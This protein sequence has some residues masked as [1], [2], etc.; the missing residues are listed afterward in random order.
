[1]AASSTNGE[2]QD[3]VRAE[4]RHTSATLE[5][6]RTVYEDEAPLALSITAALVRAQELDRRLGA[7][8][9]LGVQADAERDTARAYLDTFRRE[10]PDSPVTRLLGSG[11][12]PEAVART[13]PLGGHLAALQAS[14]RQATDEAAALWAAGDYDATRTRR[15]LWG[16]A[17]GALVVLAGF[18]VWERRRRSALATAGWTA[19]PATA[20]TRPVPWP[21]VALVLAALIGTRHEPERWPLPARLAAA[22][23]AGAA[24]GGVLFRRTP[25][26]LA[27]PVR[28][29]QADSPVA[30]VGPPSVPAAPPERPAAGGPAADRSPLPSVILAVAAVVV[31]ALQIDAS[32]T[33]NRY[34]AE[35]AQG[36]DRVGT[37]GVG[38]G[39]ARRSRPTG[40]SSSCSC[41]SGRTTSPTGHLRTGSPTPTAPRPRASPRRS[42]TWPR[43]RQQPTASTP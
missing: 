5:N 21:G 36:A 10:V 3:A 20:T 7:G 40:S 24:V 9:F 43:P 14:S 22:L 16:M 25:A 33:E 12:D 39:P 11:D 19:A 18:A 30:V 13:H 4:A 6:I 15:F 1:M 41:S 38:S 17:G 26:P 29:D 37:V 35:A 27:A 31:T 34:L 32:A 23:L 2:W 42:P 8:S 28:A